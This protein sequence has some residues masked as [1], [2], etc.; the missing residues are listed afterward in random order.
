V[1]CKR[2]RLGDSQWRGQSTGSQ[3]GGGAPHAGRLDGSGRDVECGR[4]GS[5]A[6]QSERLTD[7]GAS[8]EDRD[9]PGW[10]FGHTSG[11]SRT[12]IA[13]RRQPAM[14]VHG[15][16]PGQTSE[17]SWAHAPGPANE[18]RQGGP[19][20]HRGSA[21]RT[22]GESIWRTAPTFSSPWTLGIEQR[23]AHDTSFGRISEGRP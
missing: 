14:D 18:P 13:R 6:I 15:P 3:R 2:A 4:D 1:L 7:P 8:P 10:G 23:F 17:V 5:A 16:G 12:A 22:A 20:Q 19:N 9:R 11:Y 21:G